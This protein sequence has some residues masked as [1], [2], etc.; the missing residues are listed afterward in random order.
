MWAIINTNPKSTSG[1]KDNLNEVQLS[2]HMN[3]SH[4]AI[5]A[6]ALNYPFFID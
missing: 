5:M 1:I 2:D 3:H 6:H 4:I